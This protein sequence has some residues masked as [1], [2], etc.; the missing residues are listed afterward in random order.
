MNY[1]L[2]QVKLLGIFTVEKKHEMLEEG[3][4]MDSME[5]FGVFVTSVILHSETGA[6]EPSAVPGSVQEQV[7]LLV[8]SALRLAGFEDPTDREL[9]L[10]IKPVRA[11][12]DAREREEMRFRRS[13]TF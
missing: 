10:H 12:G 7:G 4:Q 6:S 11:C 1:E 3:T 9:R 5:N 13:F 2:Q 8:V